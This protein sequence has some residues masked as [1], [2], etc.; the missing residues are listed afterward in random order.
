MKAEII[1]IRNGLEDII[2][3]ATKVKRIRRDYYEQF[4]TNKLDN[5]KE[6]DKFLGT[7][8]LPKLNHEGI[9]NMNWHLTSKEVE[10][11]IK[12]LPGKK[13]SGPDGFTWEFYQPFKRK[14]YTIIPKFFQ[15]IKESSTLPN[16]FIRP[17]LLLYQNQIK[18]LQE[19]RTT[20][21][22]LY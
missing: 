18:I 21:W 6:M 4:Y 5:L 7:Y 9:K 16:S 17:V 3:D 8:D 11:V 12:Y 20:D 10:S 13:I 15:I 2:S 19:K 14:I 22:C 1:K